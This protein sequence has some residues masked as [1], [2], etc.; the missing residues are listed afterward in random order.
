LP[1]PRLT[2][3][4]ALWLLAWPAFAGR[5]PVLKQIQVP[6]GYY[7]REMYLPQVTSGTSS[8]TW[9]PDG[10]ELVYSM[11][12]TL[13]R[14]ALEWPRAHRRTGY[15]HQPDWSPAALHRYAATETTPWSCGCSSGH[16]RGLAADRERP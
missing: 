3:A 6:H 10:R 14:Q 12:G 5:E 1:L 4:A 8:A 2:L 16:G 15:D 9:S 13:W 11:Q 7:Y